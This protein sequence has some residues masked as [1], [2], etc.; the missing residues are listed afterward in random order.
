MVPMRGRPRPARI[1]LRLAFIFAVISC[2]LYYAVTSHANVSNIAASTAALV[3]ASSRPA[4]S[5]SD[6][7]STGDPNLRPTTSTPTNETSDDIVKR[8]YLSLVYNEPVANASIF[9]DLQA[10]YR[11]SAVR[12][13]IR[14]IPCLV[15]G[16]G[17]DC[18]RYWQHECKSKKAFGGAGNDQTYIAEGGWPHRSNAYEDN[19]W[20]EV[21]H[22][23]MPEGD[24]YGCFFNVRKGTGV[25]MNVGKTLVVRND[26]D[27]KALFH[28]KLG[29]EVGERDDAKFAY[30]CPHALKL[31]FDTVQITEWVDPWLAETTWGA[32]EGGHGV[33]QLILCSGKCETEKVESSCIPGVEFRTGLKHDK[34]CKCDESIAVLNCGNA[35]A[36]RVKRAKFCENWSWGG[37]RG[38]KGSLKRTKTRIG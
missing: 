35:I 21:T 27:A 29:V 16:F 5:D 1:R 25:F 32:T 7:I 31:G 33:H 9:D 8:E 10:I 19:E 2:A 14:L 30:Y 22:W 34:P 15:F 11:R 23:G 24:G 20:A 4:V 26:T 3:A 37:D 12:L 13:P 38:S 17:F 18:F 28:R 36:P 6:S